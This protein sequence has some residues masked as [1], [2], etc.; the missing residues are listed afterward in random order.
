MVYGWA[1]VDEVSKK[2]ILIAQAKSAR[3]LIVVDLGVIK[4]NNN[5]DTVVFGSRHWDLLSMDL[6]YVP[7][8]A[9]T[10]QEWVLLGDLVILK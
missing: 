9:N 4:N 2:T 1:C 8:Y 5:N 10:K 3:R 7:W 6:Y